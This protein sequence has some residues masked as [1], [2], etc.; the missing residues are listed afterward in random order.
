MLI[1]RSSNVR[2]LS[3]MSYWKVSQGDRFLTSE[4]INAW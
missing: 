1:V 4:D 3:F 2:S